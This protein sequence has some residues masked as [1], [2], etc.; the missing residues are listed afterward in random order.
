MAEQAVALSKEE[1]SK[2]R[3]VIGASSAGTLIEW[4]DFFIF[5]SLAVLISAK[6][7][8]SGNQVAALLSTLA[9]FG[10]GFVVRPFGALFFGRMGDLIGRKHTFLVTL[11]MMGISTFAIGLLPTYSQIGVFAPILLVILR[12]LQGLALGGEYGGAATYVAEH[13]R[14][15]ERGLFTSF[16]QTTATL[17]LFVSLGVISGTRL[18]MGEAAFDDWGWRI[19]F[20]V[21]ILLVLVSYYIRRKMDESP[22]FKE[23]KASKSESKNPLRESFV[24]PEN[25]KWVLL[26]LVGAT[27]GQG[28]VWYTG[29]FYALYYLQTVL[30]IK[31]LEANTIIA[32]A[33]AIGTPFFIFFGWLSDRVSRRKLILWGCLVA[34]L[35]YIP[36]YSAMD[37][38]AAI[39]D[40]PV[41]KSG[42][43]V[44]GDIVTETTEYEGGFKKSVKTEPGNEKPVV[45]TQLEIPVGVRWQLIGLVLIQ[46]L[47]VT[48]VYGPIAAYLVELFPTKIRYTSMSLPYHIGNGVFGGLVPLIATYAV[49]QTG[50]NHA[51]LYY[52]IGIALMTFIVGMVFLKE[53]RS[54][55]D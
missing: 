34:A 2:I 49:S 27:A 5:G 28:V 32:I 26:A 42:L 11:V 9:T 25:R 55:E 19:P 18:S 16:I 46:V 37:S 36:I 14:S 48:V 22:A 3:T 6:F 31:Q 40:R 47:F 7:F 21:S 54:I 39:G 8:P 35:S 33:L 17:G 52:P 10:V 43:A 29:Q 12:M 24:N 13:A 53:D 30:N 20:L 1:K 45:K 44:N 41:V 23:L 50:N 38:A 4:Y 15:H 51:G